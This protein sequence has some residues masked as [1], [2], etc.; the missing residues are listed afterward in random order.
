MLAC[1]VC[2][3]FP[4]FRGGSF[5]LVCVQQFQMGVHRCVTLPGHV[6][7]RRGRASVPNVRRDGVGKAAIRR[8]GSW[9]SDSPF[10]REVWPNDVTSSRHL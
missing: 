4:T 2:L 7:I 9:P 3:S 5:G 8:W 1:T 10:G 6:V